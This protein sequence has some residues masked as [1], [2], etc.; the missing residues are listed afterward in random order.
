MDTRLPDKIV[1]Y[2]LQ[3]FFLVTPNLRFTFFLHAENGAESWVYLH[4]SPS[5]SMIEINTV[6]SVNVHIFS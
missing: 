1:Q 6:V 5:L 4:L 3:G 2:C